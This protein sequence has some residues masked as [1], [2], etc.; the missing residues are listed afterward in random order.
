MPGAY[1]PHSADHIVRLKHIGGSLIVLDWGWT[2][3]P[4][5]S[6]TLIHLSLSLHCFHADSPFIP[7]DF[8]YLCHPW[9]RTSPTIPL[10]LPDATYSRTTWPRIFCHCKAVSVEKGGHHWTKWELVH[11][12]K[13]HRVGKDACLNIANDMKFGN[14]TALWMVKW[15][16]QYGWEINFLSREQITP[17][18]SIHVYATYISTVVVH[19]SVITEL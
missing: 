7:P 19:D 18:S 3:H 1:I 17:A 2:F 16:D 14:E 9:A 6:V 5:S 15:L 11:C 13:L 12:G 4:F 8:L 10:L